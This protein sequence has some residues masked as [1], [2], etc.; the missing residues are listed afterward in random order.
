MRKC[1]NRV[2]A[3]SAPMTMRGNPWHEK[4]PD[5]SRGNMQRR[6]VR[7]PSRLALG[8]RANGSLRGRSGVFPFE[9]YSQNAVDGV[10]CCSALHWTWAAWPE[11]GDGLLRTLLAKALAIVL[12]RSPFQATLLGLRTAHNAVGAREVGD[13]NVK[14]D[15][16]AQSDHEVQNQEQRCQTCGSRVR[17]PFHV[18]GP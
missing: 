7:G 11:V 14:E 18:C 16:E 2:L 6:S 15:K 17:E 5:V 4:N 3:V 1:R 13:A 10:A 8:H 9:R 12:A